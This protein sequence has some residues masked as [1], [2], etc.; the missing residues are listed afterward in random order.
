MSLARE[1]SHTIDLPELDSILAIAD[2]LSVLTRDGELRRVARNQVAG[3][4]A[5]R[6]VLLCH[7]R[8]IGRRFEVP[9]IASY[10]LLELFAFVHP[11]R[12]VLPTPAG[13][14][15]FLGQPEPA[16]P[17]D[18]VAGMAGLA[19]GLLADLAA[20]GKQAS[21][22]A[23]IAWQMGQQGW[24]WSPLILRALGAENGVTAGQAR[25]AMRVWS[26][27]PEWS[28]DG[29]PPPP[30]TVEIRENESRARLS[31]LLG[32]RSE[33][34][35]Q[36]ADYAG[37]V[38]AAFAPRQNPDSPITVLAEAGTGVGKT[39]GYLAP[40]TLWAEQAGAPVCISTFTRNLQHQID[41]ELDRLYPKI[42]EKRA[43]VVIRKGR[44]NYLCLLNLEEAASGM[45]ARPGD[46]IA[47]GLMARWVAKTRDGDMTGGDFPGWL[48]DLIGRSRT[49]GLAD[50][51][52]E[53]LFSACTHYSRCFIERGIRRAKRADIVIANHALVMI[54]AALGIG[55][56]GQLPL[57]YV[58]DEGHHLFDAADSAFAGHLTGQE[59]TD[60]RRWLIGSQSR[61]TS[62]ARGLGSRIEGLLGDDPMAEE[63]LDAINRAARA[64]PEDGW[65]N[66]LKDE[67]ANG[68]TETY[69]ALVRRQ[70]YAR[71]QGVD[72]PYG[73]ETEVSP[74][75][76]GLIESAKE[77][78]Q[79]LQRL[80]EPITALAR[81]L[82]DRLNDEADTLETATR[83]RIDAVA[84][85]LKRRGG[86]VIAGWRSMLASLTAGTGEGFVDWFGIERID[87]RDYEVGHYRHFIDPTEP[88]AESIA[89]VAHG[90][91]ITSATLTDGS[92][93]PE[94]DWLGAEQRSGVRH[95]AAPAIRAQVPSP[96]DY[97][98][99][100]RVF[101]VNDVRKDDLDQVSA[102][103]RELFLA[104]GGGGLGLFTA[105]S[106]LRAAYSRLANP[107]AEQGITVR[108]Q[109]VDGMDV[110]TLVEIFKGE[111]DSCLLGTDAV[112]DGVDVPGDSLRLIV[113]D[114]VPWPRPN[115]LHRARRAEFGSKQ[116][117][118]MLT[119]LRL[120]QAFG[121]LIRSSK[122]RGVFVLLDPMMPSR[123]LGAFGEG[124]IIER[125]GL[126]DAV[127]KTAEFLDRTATD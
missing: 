63:A 49:T 51:R 29:P 54:Q 22:A 102:A 97:A 40:A 1:S 4:L 8:S 86:V 88:F 56:E 31:Q 66:R 76:D 73:L 3:Y 61:R 95:F 121:R 71:A 38:T 101:I 75:I 123:L 104:S 106:R 67:A 122:D 24:A 19:R 37:A 23:G 16:T 65:L 25:A 18:A 84:R 117:D 87:G 82:T 20:A 30:K 110:A 39:L 98:A 68:P 13:L 99:Q 53:C 12:F 90:I 2:G 9:R 114:R 27:L 35:P 46:M 48:A 5:D 45:A 41:R 112:R 62:R 94:Q 64:L 36:Q 78:D 92:G 103:Y 52:G 107:L 14:A 55:E 116:Y 72:G 7:T 80:Q 125:T 126:A 50:R 47:I 100:T 93:D 108:A 81:C 79:A 34:R 118:D 111:I 77:L 58:F 43:K 10:D 60:L 124:A 113:F 42:S 74:S 83:Q 109:H 119:R 26:R 85:G 91:A 57:R 127:A 21:D 28:Q 105:V 17:E 89:P 70:V 96:F 15:R 69:L 33:D 59:T 115:I 32:S 6:T 120:R 11:G 44:E